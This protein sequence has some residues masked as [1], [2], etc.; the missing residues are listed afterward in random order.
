MIDRESLRSVVA[1]HGPGSNPRGDAICNA[2]LLQSS[3]VLQIF[4]LQYLDC[5]RPPSSDVLPLNLAQ[6]LKIS[7]ST[8]TGP[9]IVYQPENFTGCPGQA[10]TKTL[11]EIGPAVTTS[12][13][14]RR[15]GGRPAAAIDEI[16]RAARGA[17]GRDKRGAP[18]TTCA[19]RACSRTLQHHPANVDHGAQQTS[20]V[21][22]KGVQQKCARRPPAIAQGGARQRAS[23]GGVA[24]Q[25]VHIVSTGRATCAFMARSSRCRAR[26][27]ARGGK[28]AAGGGG[29]RLRFQ[30]FEFPI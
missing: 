19:N 22:R 8:K 13:E 1:S 26:T 20:G 24:Q 27:I 10:R 25:F 7:K 18:S 28:A 17:R 2:I 9:D 29:R 16:A 6:N 30:N 11:E 23:S 4:G 21:E 3:P 12:P 5:H 15:S 14:T